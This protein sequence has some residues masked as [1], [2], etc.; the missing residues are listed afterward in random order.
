MKLNALRR[1]AFPAILFLALCA[2]L[3]A[4]RFP[5]NLQYQCPAGTPPVFMI[6][7]PG[8]KVALVH[9]KC[10]ISNLT[11]RGVR[12]TGNDMVSRGI[13]HPDGSYQATGYEIG[14]LDDKAADTY[15]AEWD[16]VGTKAG[17]TVKLTYKSGTGPAAGITGQI[18]IKCTSV[19]A[20]ETCH[21]TGYYD[22]PAPSPKPVK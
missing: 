7:A 21:G 5:V 19:G 12:V 20:V 14:A 9:V 22:L 13:I 10:T 15:L 3:R 6:Q 18:E 1:A 8:G 11:I 4:E 16:E 17:N 2:G